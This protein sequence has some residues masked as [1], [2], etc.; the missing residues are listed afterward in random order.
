MSLN[1]IISTSG[2]KYKVSERKMGQVTNTN[3]FFGQSLPPNCPMN[4][5]AI[6]AQKEFS[7]SHSYPP[8]FMSQ[9]SGTTS[10]EGVL[11]KRMAPNLEAGSSLA[12][13]QQQQQE[14]LVEQPSSTPPTQVPS[15]V[16]ST[17]QPSIYIIP[18]CNGATSGVP[19]TQHQ[20]PLFVLPFVTPTLYNHSLLIFK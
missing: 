14:H 9:F 11:R 7:H 17:N 5:E 18:D 2:E 19:N 3:S 8:Q 20:A 6:G 16:L 15:D 10:Y 12:P 13:N 4:D 1:D